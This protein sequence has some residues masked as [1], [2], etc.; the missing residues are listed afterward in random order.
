MVAKSIQ[1][2]LRLFCGVV[3]CLDLVG[4]GSGAATSSTVAPTAP[5]AAST[6]AHTASAPT[7]A[8]TTIPGAL[9][10]PLPV[11]TTARA[12]SAPAPAGDLSAAE[13]RAIVQASFGAYP[14][15]MNQSALAKS[16]AY[17]ITNLIEAAGP[18]R[19][20]V[21]QSSPS[22]N[23]LMT[24]DVI[25]ITPTVYAKPTNQ[26][27]ALL[28]LAGL[29]NGQWGKVAPGNAYGDFSAEALRA[30]SAN[31]VVSIPDTGDQNQKIFK[32]VGTEELGGKTATIYEYKFGDPSG[33][34]GTTTTRTSIGIQDKRIYKAVSED[35]F[36]MISTIVEYVPS[37]K[38]EP[39]IP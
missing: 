19:V 24:V 31:D 33:S 17:T 8:L 29:T 34:S 30:A 12:T 27:P 10:S 11:P 25:L 18:E 5:P 3:L 37:L 36:Q 32:L 14:W 13:M 38:V 15:R 4:C 9:P 1:N 2:G 22:G 6:I 35:A 21:L 39:P 23:V 20:R 16:S 26:P 28:Q 7:T